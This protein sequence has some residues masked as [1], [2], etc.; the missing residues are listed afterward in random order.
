[1]GGECGMYGGEEKRWGKLKTKDQLGD[2][3]VGKR[4]ILERILK[5]QGGT[6]NLAEHRDKWRALVTRE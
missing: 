5:K 3:D 2:I 6:V 4:K 1:M